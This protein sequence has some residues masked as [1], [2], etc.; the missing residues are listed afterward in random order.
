MEIGSK[1]KYVKKT[2]QIEVTD[3]IQVGS[4][5]VLNSKDN[6]QDLNYEVNFDGVFERFDADELELV[7]DDTISDIRNHISPNTVVIEK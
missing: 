7:I 3:K 2:N 4:I 5:G 6:D 1:V